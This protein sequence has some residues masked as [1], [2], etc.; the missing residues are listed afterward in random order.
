MIRF[1]RVRKLRTTVS[2]PAE[3]MEAVRDLEYREGKC[4]SQVVSEL[5]FKA[6]AKKPFW[7]PAGDRLGVPTS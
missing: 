6:L 1:N 3:V 2:L 4:K 5:I 7:D